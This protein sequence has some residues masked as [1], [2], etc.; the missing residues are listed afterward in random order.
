MLMVEFS[1]LCLQDGASVSLEPG[2]QFELSGAPLEDIHACQ[3]ELDM[4]LE[5][6]RNL[7]VT[8]IPQHLLQLSIFIYFIKCL[9]LCWSVSCSVIVAGEYCGQGAWI[10]IRRHWIRAQVASLSATECAQGCG[11]L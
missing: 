6:V 2:G 9:L 5:Q 11:F 1:L 3:R 7:S 10:G 4:H 8:C